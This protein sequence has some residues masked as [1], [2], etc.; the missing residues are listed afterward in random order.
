VWLLLVDD[1]NDTRQAIAEYLRRHGHDVHT[2]TCARNALAFSNNTYDVL[3]LDIELRDL[4]GYSLARE[5]RRRHAFRV[6]PR[7][8]ALSAMPFNPDHPHA[9][10]AAFDIYLTKPTPMSMLTAT[11]DG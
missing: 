11:L 10:E 9:A 5:F 2:A 8:I 1:D 4:D 7:L 3:I 6:K